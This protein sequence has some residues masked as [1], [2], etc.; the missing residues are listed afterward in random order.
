MKRDEFTI[1]DGVYLVIGVCWAATLGVMV[2][3]LAKAARTYFAQVRCYALLD[4]AYE[5]PDPVFPLGNALERRRHVGRVNDMHLRNVETYCSSEKAAY[6][7]LSPMFFKS[8]S[9]TSNELVTADPRLVKHVLT[10]SFD[11]W[12]KS[13][14]GG[15]QFSAV[16]SWLGL[17][18]FTIDHGPHAE[19]PADAGHLWSIHRS[20][21]A[22]IFTRQLF[23]THYQNVF[24]THAH[25]LVDNLI[26]DGKEGQAQIDF[27][28]HIAGYTMDCFGEIAFSTDLGNL[29]GKSAR[30]GKAFDDAHN[31]VLRFP[32]NHLMGLML[33]ELLPEFLRRPYHTHIL[34]RF[35]AAHAELMGNVHILR[36]E[37][38]ALINKRREMLRDRTFAPSE[39]TTEHADLLGLFMRMGASAEGADGA[40]E[41]ERAKAFSDQALRDMIINF[42][43]AGRD[44][45]ASTLSWLFYELGLPENKAVL[46]AVHEEVDRVLEG[47]DPTYDDVTHL[48]YLRGALWE[49]LRLHP[50][51][52][53]IMV[54]AKADDVLPD[55]TAVPCGT[56]VSISA[57]AM[58]RSR[59]L[60]GADALLFKPSRW[61]PFEQPSPYEFPVFKA[62]RRVCLGK[63]M[64]LFESSVAAAILLKRF[65]PVVVDPSTVTYGS[66][67]TMCVHDKKAKKDQ[68]MMRLLPR[69]GA[70][71]AAHLAAEA[72]RAAAAAAAAEES[73]AKRPLRHVRPTRNRPTKTREIE[74]KEQEGTL[75]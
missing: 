45:A 19:L 13:Q 60:Y 24:I 37:T 27:Q 11:K 32:R 56:R 15:R 18:I 25:T 47:S 72:K 40:T 1:E 75:V 65:T 28:H 67:L 39:S 35:S 64:A 10:D 21:S 20:T 9:G 46:Q 49:T 51:V 61:I 38:D 12:S 6:R 54:V 26:R 17:G 71:E 41:V 44:T 43:V 2:L 5:G 14:P 73:G 70:A 16:S 7:L 55:G 58:G 4:G 53:L 66:R 48:P 69:G 8:I 74:D 36:E 23:K 68:L 33:Q 22:A 34:E 31:Q 30:F 3:V 63:D 52:P 57:Y 62:G 59:A 50:P 42:M 29:T